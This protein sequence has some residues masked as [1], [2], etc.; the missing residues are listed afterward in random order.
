M[1]LDDPSV[2]ATQ[3]NPARIREAEGAAS[4]E[5]CGRALARPRTS[6]QPTAQAAQDAGGGGEASRQQGR[7]LIIYVP[8]SM[9]VWWK[10]AQ[11]HQAVEG[12]GRKVARRRS[13]ARRQHWAKL[14]QLPSSQAYQI[15]YGV[16]YE[17]E[18]RSESGNVKC[19]AGGGGTGPFSPKHPALAAALP[20][21]RAEM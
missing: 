8:Y 4:S 5:Q 13:E 6:T 12:G 20:W 19:K 17:T 7:T 1:I 16:P 3:R 9:T 11:S 14:G 18:S 15:L 10:G 21:P 2:V